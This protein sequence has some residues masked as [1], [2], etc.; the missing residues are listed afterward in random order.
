MKSKLA[1]LSLGLLASASIVHGATDITSDDSVGGRSITAF[2]RVGQRAVGGYI[3][4]EFY[5]ENGGTQTFKAHRLVLQA[6]SQVHER[7]LVNTEIEFEYGAI[8]EGDAETSGELKLEQAWADFQLTDNH[9]FRTGIV[10][11]PFGIVN[12]LHDSDVRDTTVRPI[13]AKYIVPSTWMD[14]GAGIHGRFDIKDYT[15]NYDAYL[16]NGLTGDINSSNGLKGAKQGFKEDNN[17]AT[18]FTGRLSVSP[19]L[20]LQ[21]GFSIYKGKYSVN[22]QDGLT[23]Y[24]I[25]GMWKK[26]PIEIL[27]EFAQANIDNINDMNGYYAEARYHFFPEMLKNSLFGIGFAHPTFTLFA[28]YSAVDLDVDVDSTDDKEQITAGINYRPIETVVF[29]VE[30][31][32]NKQNGDDLNTSGFVASVA[33]GF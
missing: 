16:I 5:S 22:N 31:E 17:Q 2:D 20:R 21:T 26:G 28:R 27:G 1:M 30:G 23:L 14:T 10:L 19:T 12:V 25:D 18:S 8:L 13:Y 4:N 24:G 32:L 7:V 33:V 6:S 15:F 11:V 3:D 9:Y 29:K